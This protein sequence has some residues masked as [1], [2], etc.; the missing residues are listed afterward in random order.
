VIQVNEP[1]RYDWAKTPSA[2]LLK[3]PLVY[4][5]EQRRDQSGLVAANAGLMSSPL[6]HGPNYVGYLVEDTRPSPNLRVP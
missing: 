4:F 6:E 2:T 3:K 1:W 5:V